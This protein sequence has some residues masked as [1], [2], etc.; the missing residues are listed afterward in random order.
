EAHALVALAS[1]RLGDDPATGRALGQAFDGLVASGIWDPLLALGPSLASLLDDHAAGL[2]AHH[3]LALELVERARP[4]RA[5][6]F[7][8]PL[9]NQQTAVLRL[10]PAL[11]TYNDIAA[12]LRISVNTV[13]THLKSLYRKFGVASRREAVQRGRALGL[14]QAG[15]VI[16]DS[17]HARS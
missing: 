2:G 8:A 16:G 7:V 4:P 12:S 14:L 3:R 13:K 5:P 6:A 17:R 9:T 10:L 1:A 11:M 15:A